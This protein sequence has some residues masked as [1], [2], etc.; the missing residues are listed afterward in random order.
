MMNLA[1]NFDTDGSYRQYHSIS[2]R[3]CGYDRACLQYHK[4][5]VLHE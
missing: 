4:K 1:M 2:E 3:G 5:A